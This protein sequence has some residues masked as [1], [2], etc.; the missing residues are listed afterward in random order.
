MDGIHTGVTT[1]WN[2]S[3]RRKILQ[4]LC[5]GSKELISLEDIF[6]QQKGGAIHK[7]T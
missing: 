2:K 3:S 1:F 4:N 5:Y 7:L 6:G